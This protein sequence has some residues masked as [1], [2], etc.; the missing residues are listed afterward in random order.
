MDRPTRP[1]GSPLRSLS[2]ACASCAT[3]SAAGKEAAQA[4]AIS[5]AKGEVLVFTD[6]TADVAPD[7]LRWIVRP[8]ADATVGAVSSEDLVAV[9]GGEGA[10]VRYE[11][12]LRRL[13]SEAATIVG[14]SGSFFAVRRELASPWPSDLASDFRSALESARRGLRAVSEPRAQASFRVVDDP[15][16]EWRRKV[17]TVRRGIAVLTAYREL[18]HPRHGRVALA[19]WGHKV[20]RFTSP[21][22]LLLVFAASWVASHASVA[23]TRAVQAQLLLYA[24]GGLA[25]VFEPARRWSRDRGLLHAR[26]RLDAGRLGLPPR[27]PTRGYLGADAAVS[28]ARW[29]SRAP[30]RGIPDPAA[31]AAPRA[32]G[33]GTRRRS[34]ARG[35]RSGSGAE[36]HAARVRARGDARRIPVSRRAQR[37]ERGRRT[38]VR[39]LLG[40]GL[41][42][43]RGS[44][45]APGRRRRIGA[46]RRAPPRAAPARER[47]RARRSRTCSESPSRCAT[48]SRSRAPPASR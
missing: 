4:R 3:R 9:E 2:A 7:S 31:R 10:Y 20:A 15:R 39:V 30:R 48:C 38:R 1:T 35:W 29:R 44:L 32:R 21:F 24:F 45:G 13:E 27:G 43:R 42:G 16:A 26:E 23:A 41:G 5:E 40:P 18:L 14:C 19:L 37:P 46:D 11:M 17:R 36:R 47:R 25:L 12:A 33:R 34:C 22:A 6:V 8:F 28:P